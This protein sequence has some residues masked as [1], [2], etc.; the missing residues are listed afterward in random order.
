MSPKASSPVRRLVRA[1]LALLLLSALAAGG[2]YSDRILSRPDRIGVAACSENLVSVSDAILLHEKQRG[3]TPKTLDD[4]VPGTLS[5]PMAFC[6]LCREAAGEGALEAPDPKRKIRWDPAMRRLSDSAPHRIRG[7]FTRDAPLVTRTVPPPARRGAAPAGREVLPYVRRGDLA[8]TLKAVPAIPPPAPSP[9]PAGHDALVFEAE[10]FSSVNWGWELKEDP[11]ASGGRLILN[12][13]G[14]ANDYALQTGFG[15]FYNVGNDRSPARLLYRFRI[16]EGGKWCIQARMMATGTH[17]SN[18]LTLHMDGRS[19]RAGVFGSNDIVPFRWTWDEPDWLR[20]DAG[21]HVL[22]VHPWEDGVSLD[23][24]RIA[25][26]PCEGDAVFEA[27]AEALPAEGSGVFLVH[28]L[29]TAVLDSARV[30]EI[31]VWIRRVGESKGRARLRTTIDL[32]DGRRVLVDRTFD[33]SGAKPLA[34]VPVVLSGIPI[35]DLPRR[36]YLL[37]SV[38]I[39][40]GTEAAAATTA[41]QRPFAWEILGMLSF[42]PLEKRL[43]PD[44][45]GKEGSYEIRGKTCAWKPFENRWL[46]HFGVLDFGL[47][48]A[49]NSLFAPERKTVYARTRVRAPADGDYLLK[50][51]AD[52]QMNLWVDGNEILRKDELGPVTRTSRRIP[53]RLSAGTHRLQFRLN[54]D[55]DRWQGAVFVRNPDDSISD[56]RGEPPGDLLP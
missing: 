22:R 49:G 27:N 13:E 32:P 15:D 26:Q 25:K 55:K 42:A 7:L 44:G 38:L 5:E 29:D 35:R 9:Q 30:P 46:D 48:F 23:Q 40:D 3:E 11:A 8:L 24:I 31:G 20:L 51:L 36:E 21:V 17:C 47:A 6:A 18:N 39:V 37:K 19:E 1:M 2:A 10:K 56:V 16:P 52:D 4:L 34:R 14:V 54:Q 12:K 41:L 50:V 53:V 45:W 33:L 28:D 43:P